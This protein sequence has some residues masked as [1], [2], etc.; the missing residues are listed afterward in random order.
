LVQTY[1]NGKNIPNDHKLYQNAIDCTK[2]PLNIS[3]DC[4]MRKHF[5]FQGP[6]KFT[7][8]WIFGLNTNHLA[9]LGSRG[10]KHGGHSQK[11]WCRF[12]ESVSAVI[13]SQIP[14]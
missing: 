5:P 3:N 7:Q 6:P 2:W 13:Y 4:K 12:N 11:T 9:T 1:Q 8:I 10:G 14:N